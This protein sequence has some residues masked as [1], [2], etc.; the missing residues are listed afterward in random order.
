MYPAP[1]P[2]AVN[3]IPKIK[4]N[5]PA[6]QTRSV[7]MLSHSLKVFWFRSLRSWGSGGG[8]GGVSSGGGWNTLLSSEGDKAS[9]L[10]G[11]G[12]NFFGGGGVGG[13]AEEGL[14]P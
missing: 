3:A 11:A 10:G 12:L 5:W 14:P 2:Y 7:H 9:P 1:T 6:R 13:R 8:G 4:V